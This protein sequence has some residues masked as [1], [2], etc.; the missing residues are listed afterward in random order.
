VFRDCPNKCTLLIRDN[1]EY[2]SASDS[3][4]IGHT[5]FATDHAAKTDIHVNLG[6][7]DRYESLVVQC[8]L[9]TQV[10][11]AKKNQRHTLFYTKGIIQERSIRIIIDSGSGN[12]LAGT[13]LVAREVIITHSQASESIFHSVA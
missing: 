6:D 10:T 11:P 3:K 9:S 7:T 13:I 12:N 1:S 2:S 4:E 8:V 5:F